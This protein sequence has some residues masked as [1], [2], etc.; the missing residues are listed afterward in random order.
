MIGLRLRKLRQERKISCRQLG[1]D[2]GLSASALSHYETGINTP[3]MENVLKIAEYFHVSVD[4]LLE[5]SE[6]RNQED[7]QKRVQK[8]VVKQY[9]NKLI[10]NDLMGESKKQAIR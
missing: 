8:K 1:K 5:R 9:I 10:D 3:C 7:I 2:I 4:Y 6:F